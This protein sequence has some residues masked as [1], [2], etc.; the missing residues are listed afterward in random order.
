MGTTGGLGFGLGITG[1]N[2]GGGMNPA[3]GP[4]GE[5]DGISQMKAGLEALSAGVER[6]MVVLQE[7]KRMEDGLFVGTDAGRSEGM[8]C[9]LGGLSRLEC[10]WSFLLFTR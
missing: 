5:M 6:A 1:M 10:E 4:T 9:G 7:I 3:N 8:E 2:A